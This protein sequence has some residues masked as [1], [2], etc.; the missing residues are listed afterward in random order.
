MELQV[1]NAYYGEKDQ[2][3]AKAANKF[4]G[5]GSNRSSTHFYATTLPKEIANCGEYTSEDRVFVSVEGNRSGRLSFDKH[6]VN[7]AIAARAKF[8]TDNLYHRSREYNIGERELAHYLESVGYKAI[9]YPQG[10][11]WVR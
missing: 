6:E 4:I 2:I 7:L 11:V 5:R 3:K 10:A 9:D 8:I 1:R